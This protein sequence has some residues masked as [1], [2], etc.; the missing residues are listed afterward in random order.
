MKES[1]FE[2]SIDRLSLKV[3]YRFNDKLDRKAYYLCADG[4]NVTGKI[5][6]YLLTDENNL[7]Y[8]D[9]K[10]KKISVFLPT[11][12]DGVTPHDILYFFDAQNLFSMAGDYTENGDPYGSWQLDTVICELQ[13]QFGKKIIVV[14]IL[15]GRGI[16]MS[17]LLIHIIVAK[18]QL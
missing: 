9:D 14:G 17:D 2:K 15:F 3:D 10:S 16:V 4:V 18:E 13:R 7:Y 1:S 6:N 12:Y 11:G 5:E 8:R